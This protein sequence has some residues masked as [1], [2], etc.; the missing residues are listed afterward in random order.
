MRTVREKL[1]RLGS[2]QWKGSGGGEK[3]PKGVM[4]CCAWLML[5]M[6]HTRGWQ[7]FRPQVALP[8]SFRGELKRSD[9]QTFEHAFMLFECCLASRRSFSSSV[10]QAARK[11][12][13]RTS[14]SFRLRDKNPGGGRQPSP[15][16]PAFD[17]N[18]RKRRFRARPSFC[19]QR[20]SLKQ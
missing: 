12:K 8:G 3:G 15:P 6:L 13:E 10:V 14:K 18:G 1:R 5:S 4:E 11:K 7:S 17:S 9:A 20:G 2:W 16:L 19:V